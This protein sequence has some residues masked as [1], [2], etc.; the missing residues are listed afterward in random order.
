MTIHRFIIPV[1]CSLL[2]L[3]GYAATPNDSIPVDT[4]FLDDGSLYVGQVR[5][6]LLNGRGMCIFPDGTVYD[7]EW[8]DGLWNGQGVVVYPDGDIYKGEFINHIKEGKGTYIYNSGAR[9][10]G[11]WKADMFNGQGRLLFEDGGTY[12]GA[13]KDDMKHGYGR[14]VSPEGQ[15][16]TGYFYYD[17]YLGRPFDTEISIDST[18]TQELIDWGF[19]QEDPHVKTE[20][21]WGV[22]YG[23]KGMITA[24][25]WHNTSTRFFYGA[26]LGINLD[27]PTRGVTT[28]EI[29]FKSFTND[30]HFTGEY[31]SSEYM[32]DAGYNF[33]KSR[34]SAGVSLGFGVRTLYMNCKA[35]GTPDFYDAYTVDY[36]NAYT[37]KSHENLKP[38]YRGYLKY[39]FSKEKPKAHMYLGYGSADGLFMGV[40]WYVY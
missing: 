26:T 3:A 19:R 7:G 16:T 36:G 35:N 1:I 21:M 28:V 38:V 34:L 24:S 31:I 12:E 4:L 15:A 11:E 10:D 18:M 30:I 17:E 32:F 2:S 33:I 40:S 14:L 27:P 25:L 9:Y 8:K 39:S 20:V 6:S 13:W 5:D 22:S 23:S 37:R 29:G